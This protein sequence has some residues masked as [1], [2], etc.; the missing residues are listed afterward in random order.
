MIKINEESK[1]VI[2]RKHLVV[3]KEF[4]RLRA[5]KCSIINA[6]EGKK[7]RMNRSIQAEGSFADIKGDSRFTRFLCRGKDN[8]HAE[9]ILYAMAHDIGWSH[10]RIQGDKTDL[11]L[12]EL[13]AEENA[14]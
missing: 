4:E 6:E 13:K 3:S 9:S 2:Y 8:V 12:Y 14:A 7:L 5:K 1:G 10:T 11:R